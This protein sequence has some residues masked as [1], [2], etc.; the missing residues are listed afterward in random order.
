MSLLKAHEPDEAGFAMIVAMI[1][2]TVAILLVTSV[3]ALGIHLDGATVR[4]RKLQFALQV[5]E[6]GADQAAADITTALDSG[7]VYANP[8][9]SVSVPGGSYQTK[10]TVVSNGYQID[11]IGTVQ[12]IKRRIR[13]QYLPEPSFKYAL[14]SNTSLAVK[15]AG[16]V[17]GDVF[18]NLD[19]ELLNG[20]IVTGGVTSA[21]GKVFLNENAKVKKAA[22]D[23][24]GFVT[25]GGLNTSSSPQ[26]GVR[27]DNGAVIDGDV[28]T[29]VASAGTP[30]PSAA[31]YNI[32]NDGEI[33]GKVFLP[34]SV[35][36]TL[37]TGGPSSVVYACTARAATGGSLPPFNVSGI[38]GLVPKTPAEFEAMPFLSGKIFV[39]GG[40]DESIDLAGQTVN[41]DFTLVTQVVI[42]RS[43]TGV[44]P[45]STPG[46]D[47]TIHLISTNTTKLTEAD[48]A[49]N[50]DDLN[51]PA[52]PQPSPALLIYSTGYCDLKN[53]IVTSGAVYCNGI[54]I[55][56]NI[57]IRYDERIRKVLGFGSS[58]YVKSGF[59]E[60]ASSTPL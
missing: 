14:F 7:T 31:N 36:G 39:T 60:L 47:K 53:T 51:L 6:A 3:L 17:D 33:K 18:G 24:G 45:F 22:D 32:R 5:A 28:K 11:S 41:G 13:V 2:S 21:T 26:W 43:N 16:G 57:D 55:K 52:S 10:A 34:G 29:L 54:N 30:C 48:P 56:N 59:R 8:S 50:I 1:I 37:P 9:G 38:A 15:S 40:Q 19:V 20:T 58:L 35:E 4:D 12:G 42:K 46:P 44:A 49:I 27:L 25:S 23:T